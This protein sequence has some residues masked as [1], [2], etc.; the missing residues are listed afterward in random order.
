MDHI[1]IIQTFGV[2]KKTE[3][4]P[5]WLDCHIRIS[6]PCNGDVCTISTGDTVYKYDT[7][8]DHIRIIHIFGGT[9]KIEENTY[10]LNCHIQISKPCSGKIWTLL[11]ILWPRSPGKCEQD[12][13]IEQDSNL[14]GQRPTDFKSVPLTTP[15]PILLARAEPLTTRAQLYRQNHKQ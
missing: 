9:K 4:N 6:K 8:M 13:R 2:T 5:Y 7:I 1:R 12:L 10:S 15:A 14:C 3:E 11:R